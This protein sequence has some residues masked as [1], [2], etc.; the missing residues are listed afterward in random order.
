MKKILFDLI[1]SSLSLFENPFYN[2]MAMAIK[3][4]IAF[5][6]AFAI[7]G[8]LGLRGEAGSIA[9]WIIRL[10]IFAFIWLICCIA[11]VLITF[12][13]NNWIIITISGILLLVIYVLKIYANK[14]PKSI[15]NKKIF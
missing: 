15:L 7:V 8:E 3:G 1:T 2:Y 9:H 13:I 10:F 5:K 6:V 12:I 11:I 4:F 14:N